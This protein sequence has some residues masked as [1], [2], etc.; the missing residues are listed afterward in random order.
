MSEYSQYIESLKKGMIQAIIFFIIIS[1]V[2]SIALIVFNL[3]LYKSSNDGQISVK[4]IKGILLKYKPWVH[5]I[6]AFMIVV[7]IPF[8]YFKLG[9]HAAFKDYQLLNDGIYEIATL[10]AITFAKIGAETPSFRAK[11]IETGEVYWIDYW[12]SDTN[13]GDRFLV[14]RTIHTKRIKIVEKNR[15]VIYYKKITNYECNRGFLYFDGLK[16]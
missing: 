5:I 2:I 7:L 6:T 13:I 8:G 12:L 10:E 9:Y 4:S 3:Y 11:D 16:N 14:I 1:L 15:I